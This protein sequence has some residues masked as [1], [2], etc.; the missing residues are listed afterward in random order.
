MNAERGAESSRAE[1]AVFAKVEKGRRKEKRS[2]RRSEKN[3]TERLWSKNKHK[4]GGEQP[5]QRG[6][7]H[8][9]LA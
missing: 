3:G 9:N 1:M 7:T 6:E 2:S 8:L 4:L 5:N